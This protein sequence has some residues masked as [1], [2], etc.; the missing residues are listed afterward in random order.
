MYL[1]QGR[2][3]FLLLGAMA[4]VLAAAC[5]STN[6]PIN[7]VSGK[8]IATNRPATM[9]EI[10]NAILAAGASSTRM[11]M[12]QERPGVIQ[13]T[14]TG[15]KGRMAIMEIKYDTKQYSITYK[16]SQNMNY[17]G[18]QIL[19]SYNDW[20]ENLDKAILARLQAL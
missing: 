19:Q 14:R 3:A 10:G 17:D 7:N 2:R 18:K 8:S 6:A 16:D 13:A 11:Q 20:V 12:K 9:A 1:I 5:A 4:L 15:T